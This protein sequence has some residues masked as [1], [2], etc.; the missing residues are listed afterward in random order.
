MT[1]NTIYRLRD[2]IV[3]IY[4]HEEEYLRDIKTPDIEGYNNML[5]MIME[6]MSISSF[7]EIIP[8]YIDTIDS[9]N[10]SLMSQSELTETLYRFSVYGLNRFFEIGTAWQELL[11]I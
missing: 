5:G 11:G 1:Y 9:I 6:K 10:Y 7:D 2:G 3:E 8:A 4:R